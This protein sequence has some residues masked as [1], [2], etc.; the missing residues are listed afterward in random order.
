ML[1]NYKV[2]HT[3][4]AGYADIVYVLIHIT[5]LCICSIDNETRG[6]HVYLELL[7]QSD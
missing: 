7:D 5:L 3:T 2:K 4:Y 6:P 1:A